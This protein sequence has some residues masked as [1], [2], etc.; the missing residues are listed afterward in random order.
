MKSKTKYS[1]SKSTWDKQELDA[2]NQVV[3]SGNFTMGANVKKFEEKFAKYFNS[4]YAV[5]VNSGSSANLLGIASLFYKKSNPLMPGDEVIVPAVSWSTTYSPLQQYGLKLKFVDVDIETLNFDIK[6]L[7]QAVSSKTRIILAVNLLGN[8]NEFNEI[9][10]IINR[11]DI[12]L[13]EDNCESMGAKFDDE[14]AGSIGDIGTFSM[15]YSHH[16]CTMEGGM[17]LTNEIELYHIMLSLRAHGWT[18]DLPMNN[19]IIRKETDDFKESFKFILPGYNLRPLEMSAAIGIKQLDKLEKFVLTRRSN[20]SIFKTLFDSMDGVSIQKETGYSSWFGFSIILDDNYDRKMI[21]EQL[22][23]NYIETR[24]IVSGNILNNPML[25]YFN[26]EISGNIIN[27]E[28]I[29][30]YGF[31]VGNNHHD[32]TE[33]LNNFKK[34]LY[35][36]LH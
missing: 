9:K 20:A 13:F 25:K 2:I 6:K 15:F 31:F 32:L 17:I 11:K 30:N 34:I 16:I 23:K 7:K 22:K 35:E 27:A 12:I 3:K 28:K 21:L 26:Y 14:Y 18:R 1:L 33:E 10:K 36:S 4:N 19:S 8:P 5:M 29:S 24:P